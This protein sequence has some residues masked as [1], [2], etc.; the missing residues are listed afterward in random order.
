MSAE[1]SYLPIA[2]RQRQLIEDYSF[3]EDPTERFSALIDRGKQLPP[4]PDDE[5][6]DENLVQGCTSQV[7]LS[8]AL[9]QTGRCEFHIEAD[10]SIVQGMAALL[11]TLYSDAEI[12]EIL[13]VEP[14]VIA[15]LKIDH[16]L[17]PTRL[18]GTRQILKRMRTIARSLVDS[19]QTSPQ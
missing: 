16:H 12:S 7:W 1:T 11:A 17:S 14:D 10:S 15:V 5:R 4:V 6:I 18:N 13:R 9:N 19:E 2:E 8:G 3:I